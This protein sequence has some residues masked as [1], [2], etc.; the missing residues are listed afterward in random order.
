M[1]GK[2]TYRLFHGANK[3]GDLIWEGSRLAWRCPEGTLMRKF[4]RGVGVN[5]AVQFISDFYATLGHQDTVSAFRER[6]R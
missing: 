2:F 5:K 6:R 3:L 4:H 1:R